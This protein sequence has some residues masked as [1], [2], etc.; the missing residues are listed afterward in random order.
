MRSTLIGGCFLSYGIGCILVN[1]IT[2]Y[3]KSADVLIF[4]C[5]GLII[6]SIIPSF[7]SYY[8]TPQFLYQKGRVT[9]LFDTLEG[10]ASFNG[11]NLQ[12]G[13]F[14]R[15]LVEPSMLSVL[16]GR[17]VQIKEILNG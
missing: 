4:V 2:I 17:R 6:L 15:Q 7:F 8:E 13:Y 9:E 16:D 12:K 10:I 3:V 11:K 1:F 14:M 5:G